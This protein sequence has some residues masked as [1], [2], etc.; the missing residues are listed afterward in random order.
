MELCTKPISWLLDKKFNIPTYQR[1]YRWDNQQITD[2]LEDLAEYSDTKKGAYYCLQPVAVKKNK[3]APEKYDVIDGQQR[4]TSIYLILTYLQSQ[5]DN[6]HGENSKKMYS[7]KFDNRDDG[8]LNEKQFLSDTE[9]FKYNINDFYIFKA[10]KT[11]E[12]WFGTHK[13]YEWPIL[14]VLLG[15][16]GTEDKRITKIIW[17]DLSETNDNSISIFTRLNHGKIPLNDAELIKAL[18]FE[19]DR[20][21]NFFQ[22]DEYDDDET[23]REITE[24]N[25]LFKTKRDEI[26]FRMS[27]EW[28]E[29]EKKLNNQFFWSFISS[30]E[31]I[32]TTRI[33]IILDKIARDIKKENPGEYKYSEE[34]DFFTYHVLNHWLKNEL[35]HDKEN[36]LVVSQKN[37]I[38]R[39]WEKIQKVFTVFQNWFNDRTCYHLIGFLQAVIEYSSK[40]NKLKETNKLIDY[41][42]EEY[43]HRTKTDFLNFLNKEVAKRIKVNDISKLRYQKTEKGEH[44]PSAMV[45]ILLLVNV[46]YFI[47][48]PMEKALYPFK[49]QKKQEIISLEHIHPQ[50][51]DTVPSE[52]NYEEIKSW[53]SSKAM[54]LR[55]LNEGDNESVRD[56]GI[57]QNK[58]EEEKNNLLSEINQFVTDR[59]FY[60]DNLD[61]CQDLINRIDKHFNDYSNLNYEEIHS[62]RNMALVD[63]SLNTALSNNF[64]DKK[65]SILIQKEKEGVY[66]PPVTKI[67]FN[68]GFSKDAKNLVFWETPDREAY[69]AEI[70][71]IYNI[72]CK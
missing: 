45:K 70:E 36:N 10:Y 42:F 50:N 37:A 56:G 48:H 47:E 12:K 71:R 32:P 59:N 5:R 15:T 40:T 29:M 69:F 41:L 64:L 62:L 66:V 6:H 11:I 28:D 58:V 68:K 24:K 18:L 54:Y 61:N 19:C 16:K 25:K 57:E 72:Y 2:L 9:K 33:S 21:Q 49:K 60:F 52:D 1:G 14:E 26:A 35:L 55:N 17:Y 7:L 46:H 30:S 23:K 27:T 65:R 3:D 39:L 31:Y 34:K 67:C 63:C 51:L 22:I 43:S 4:L 8:Y 20:Y 53:L 13:S 38:D 44:N